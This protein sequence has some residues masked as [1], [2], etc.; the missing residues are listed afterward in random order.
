MLICFFPDSCS[1]RISVIFLV[2]VDDQYWML[3]L[4]VKWYTLMVLSCSVVF[5]V[6]SLALCPGMQAVDG[7]LFDRV[8]VGRWAR[9]SAVRRPREHAD[10]AHRLCSAASQ[11]APEA[12]SPRD[13]W[14]RRLSQS[15]DAMDRGVV[16]SGQLHRHAAHDGRSR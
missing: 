6:S 1:Q 14:R 13:Q 10:L 7:I 15:I 16:S 2:I 4:D 11:H 3:V 5:S 12:P 8:T 9:G